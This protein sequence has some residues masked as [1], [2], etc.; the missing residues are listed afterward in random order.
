MSDFHN[1]KTV[2]AAKEYGCDGCNGKI[3]KGTDHVYGSGSYEGDF[4]TSR[5]HSDCEKLVSDVHF[6]LGE[7]E[8]AQPVCDMKEFYDDLLT[9]EEIAE[10]DRIMNNVNSHV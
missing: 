1:S 3:T 7:Y 6:R 2:K 10:I 9:D 8:G 5:M 4:Y